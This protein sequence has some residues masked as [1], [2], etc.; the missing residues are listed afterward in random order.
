MAV[1]PKQL[2]DAA[3]R[4]RSA[5]RD[6]VVAYQVWTAA[7]VDGIREFLKAQAKTT[8]LTQA[9][10]TAQMEA[11]H[12]AALRAKL[13]AALE[14]VVAKFHAE[15]RTLDNDAILANARGRLQNFIDHS[16]TLAVPFT[17]MLDDA[18]YQSGR[19]APHPG[20]RATWTFYKSGQTGRVESMEMATEKV[21][22]LNSALDALNLANRE[23]AK[24]QTEV[25]R[26][27]AADLW[28][29]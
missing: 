16:N 1:T 10:R 11:G 21:G 23:Q 17:N 27:R 9:E 13:D 19:R 5:E 7:Q 14:E 26:D 25:D 28:G 24:M 20:I 18:G 4:V 8:A 15:Y 12:V 6:V 29:D 3:E 2:A 22:K